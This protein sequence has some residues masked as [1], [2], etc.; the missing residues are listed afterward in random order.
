MEHLMAYLILNGSI[1]ANNSKGNTPDQDP[2]TQLVPHHHSACHLQRL[3][4]AP[5]PLHLRPIPLRQRGH[6]G[7]HLGVLGRSS[8]RFYTAQKHPFLTKQQSTISCKIHSFPSREIHRLN[9]S[10]HF[11]TCVTPA[12]SNSESQSLYSCITQL[13]RFPSGALPLWN[14]NVFFIPIVWFL[15]RTA[16]SFP[17]AFQYPLPVARLSRDPFP[18]FRSTGLKKYHSRSL[19]FKDE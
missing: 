1:K 8:G 17:V 5:P 4:R 11:H 9:H 7:P 6:T 18:Y 2:C 16:L 10:N 15:W 13:V 19:V 14:T 3:L 12:R